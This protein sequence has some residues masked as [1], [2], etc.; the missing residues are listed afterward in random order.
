MNRPES[1]TT[2][3]YQYPCQQVLLKCGIAEFFFV[4][5]E[6]I[7]QGCKILGLVKTATPLKNYL[8][9]TVIDTTTFTFQCNSDQSTLSHRL[10]ML[11]ILLTDL[12]PPEFFEDIYYLWFLDFYVY[13]EE[14]QK[15][16]TYF[17]K[18]DMGQGKTVWK[19]SMTYFMERTATSY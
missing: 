12:S 13:F 8:W 9:L 10:F 4:F 16:V 18:H 19:C 6:Q 3:Q 11:S 14:V 5:D 1:V 7:Y 15:F 2:N 17:G